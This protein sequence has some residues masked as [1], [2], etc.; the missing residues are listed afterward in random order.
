MLFPPANRFG[1]G[2]EIMSH[3]IVW[4]MTDAPSSMYR[5]K[6]SNAAHIFFSSASLPFFAA[7]SD[8]DAAALVS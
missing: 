7:V 8:S 3:I 1:F 6:L 2:A 5:L 4:S